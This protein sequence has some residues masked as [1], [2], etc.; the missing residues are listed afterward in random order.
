MKKCLLCKKC[1]KW[2]GTKPKYCSRKCYGVSRRGTGNSNYKGGHYIDC[3]GY[4]RIRLPYND[5]R[6]KSHPYI[7]EHRMVMEKH[8]N[9]ILKSIEIVH[10]INGNKLDNRIRNLVVTNQS[11][12]ASEHGKLLNPFR[13]RK[14]G[15]YIASK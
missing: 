11:I 15:R 4:K 9:R 12:H 8:L 14:K 10:H 5:K 6:N 3:D 7:G 13:K 2:N 1:V